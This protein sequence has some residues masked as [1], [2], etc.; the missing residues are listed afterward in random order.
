MITIS[1][2]IDP[3]RVGFEPNTVWE[4]AKKMERQWT[5]GTEV[6]GTVKEI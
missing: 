2:M 4:G 3:R 6:P 1:I 5:R